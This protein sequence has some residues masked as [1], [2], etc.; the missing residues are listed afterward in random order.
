MPT[1]MSSPVD[2]QQLYFQVNESS[3]GFPSTAT[4]GGLN[5]QS[6]EDTKETTATNVSVFVFCIH[7]LL[8]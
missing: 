7:P 2:V 1:T 8:V 5:N 6:D 3:G 4:S